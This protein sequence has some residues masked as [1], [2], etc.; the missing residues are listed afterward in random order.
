MTKTRRSSIYYDYKIYPS[1][2]PPQEHFEDRLGV[3][4]VGAG[5]SGLVT[6]LKLAQLGVASTV[7]NAEQQVTEGSRAIVYTRRSMEILHGIG[8]ADRVSQAALPWRFGT[9]FYRG[10]PVY[11]LQAPHDDHQ[12]FFPMSNLQQQFLEQYLLEACLAN[13]L[14][15][16]RFGNRLQS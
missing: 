3:V 6:A 4:I 14:I 8:V 10:K 1:W 7:L 2:L 9:S 12:R 5:P 11:R 15:D 13:P 16:I